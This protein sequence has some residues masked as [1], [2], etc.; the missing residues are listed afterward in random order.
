MLKITNDGRKLALDQRLNDPM[1]PDDDQSKVNACL[2]NVYRIWTEN[3]DQRSAQLVFCDLSTPHNDGNFNV[4]DDLRRK[5]IERGVPEGAPLLKF[6][7]HGL[8]S[9]SAWSKRYLN[10]STQTAEFC[11]SVLSKSSGHD[12]KW[13]T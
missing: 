5:L 8:P 4:Y 3:T 12:L 1:L 11:P 7:T 13:A 6:T 9:F 2:E 10:P